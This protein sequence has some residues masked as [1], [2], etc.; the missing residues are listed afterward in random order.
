[1]ESLNRDFSLD[2]A[3][4]PHKSLGYVI[5]SVPEQVMSQEEL[6]ENKYINNLNTRLHDGPVFKITHSKVETF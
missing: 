6:C 1:M 5:H 3:L 4:I 2:I